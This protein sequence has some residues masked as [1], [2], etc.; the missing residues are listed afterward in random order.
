MH[1]R[2]RLRLRA[3]GWLQVALHC[4]FA[5]VAASSGGARSRF[6]SAFWAILSVKFEFVPLW[7]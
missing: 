4:R 6:G 1:C 5:T 2:A 3:T 7:L